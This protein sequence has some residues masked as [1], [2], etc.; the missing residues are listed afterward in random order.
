MSGISSNFNPLE[1]DEC[2]TFSN[3]LKLNN[4]PHAHIANESRS[5]SQSAIIRGAKLKKMG[6][7]KGVWDYEVYVPIKGITGEVDCYELLK[8]EM[9]RRKGGVVS[10]EQKQWGKIYELAGIPCKI[11]KGADEAIAFVNNYLKN[12]F[13]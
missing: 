1:D 11:C 10:V 13:F 9:K 12:E 8:I 5:S 3:W 4:I 2:I 7:S 6:Q